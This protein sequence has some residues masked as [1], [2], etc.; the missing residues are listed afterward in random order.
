MRLSDYFQIIRPEYVYL[1]LTPTNSIRNYNSDKI[2]KAVHTLFKKVNQRIRKL[3]G[4]IFF[5]APSK[6]SYYIYIE[7]TKVEFYFIIPKLYLSLFKEK[8]QDTWK[9]ITITQVDTIPIFTQNALKY[10]LTYSKED[11]LSLSIDRRTN[12]LLSSNLNVIDVMEE[13]DR[14]GIFYNFIPTNQKIFKAEYKNT[15]NRVNNNH[16]VDRQKLSFGYGGKMLLISVLKL[17]EMLTDTMTEALGGKVQSKHQSMSIFEVAVAQMNKR[18][19][20]AATKA[21]KDKVVLESQII[22]MS[23]SKDNTR[24]NNNAIAT[25]EGFKSISEEGG[26]DLIYRK[27]KD[28]KSFA[29]FRKNKYNT[30]NLLNLR[31]NGIESNKISVDECQNFLSLP[32]RELLE[33]HGC[34]EKIDTYESEVPEELQQGVMCIGDNT[35]KGKKTKAYLTTD[36]EYKNLTLVVIG[37]TRAGKTTLFQNLNKDALDNHEC[38]IALD[39]VS[40]CEFSNEISEVIPQNKVLTIKYTDYDSIQGL[41]YNEIKIT[42][43][44]DIFTAYNKAKIQTSQLMTLVNSINTDDKS[45]A[46]KMERYLESAALITFISN[47]AIND[48]FKVLQNHRDR[49]EYINKI[50]D[51]QKENLEEYVMSL[52]ELDELEKKQGFVVGTK[53]YLI[54]GIMDRL[55]KLKRNSYMEMAL[56]KNCDNN[57]NLVEEIEKAQ[58]I[59]IQMPDSA[60][61][62]QTE[63]DIVSTY[64]STKIW[65]ALQIR[66]M[67]I[68]DRSKHTKVNLYIDEIYQVNNTEEFWTTKLSQ[69][70]K[71][72]CKMIISCHHLE[73][74]KII[75]NELKSANASYM[76]IAGCDEKNFK[77]MANLLY[78]YQLEDLLN[79]KRF[80]SLNLI[81]YEQGYAKF[82]TLLPP[83]IKKRKR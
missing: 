61:F 48:V 57:I 17:L 67:Q 58:L 23:E 66:K 7:N 16:P 4:R 78:P 10:Y 73:Q 15:L 65:L 52:E 72:G 82:I 18:E 13:G 2:A 63:K 55:S 27:Y 41:G 77:E 31:L 49:H 33:E 32:G 83:E 54:T 24:K 22:V 76:M 39:F 69:M 50:P 36:K 81:K 8:I 59:K 30:V 9:A 64:W 28:N 46:P 68:P 80:Q 12:T 47:G 60:F 11:A 70:A 40:E 53:H 37:P 42:P 26:N 1:K 43:S 56:K 74:L 45:L 62:T 38:N 29:I 5:E 44:D 19:A 14:I 51:N 3:E 20:S 71:F 6:V 25:C 79:L 75:R 21:K 35:F 34:I